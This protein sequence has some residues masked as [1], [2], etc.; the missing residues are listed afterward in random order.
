MKHN[1][2]KLQ[3]IVRKINVG[4]FYNISVSKWDISF[5]AEYSP[6]IVKYLSTHKFS[7]KI[8]SSGFIIFERGTIRVALTS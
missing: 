3:L 2:R 6:I 1:L 7:M 5:S 8:D 4:L